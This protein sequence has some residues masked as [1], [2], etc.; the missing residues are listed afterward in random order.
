MDLGR[1]TAG[2]SNP[3]QEAVLGPGSAVP[4]VDNKSASAKLSLC[5]CLCDQKEREVAQVN[6]EFHELL[7]ASH[8]QHTAGCKNQVL[9]IFFSIIC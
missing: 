6:L 9:G 8:R 4:V 7:S 3:P 5:N 1:K 2:V